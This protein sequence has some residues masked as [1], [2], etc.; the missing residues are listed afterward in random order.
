MVMYFIRELCRLNTIPNNLI[1]LNLRTDLSWVQRITGAYPDNTEIIVSQLAS[2]NTIRYDQNALI[3]Q[4]NMSDFFKPHFYPISFFYL[5]MLTRKDDF[6]L[7]LPNLSMKKIFIEYFNDI[8]HIDTSTRYTE[9]MERFIV[10]NP[11][12][13]ELFAGYWREYVSQLPEAIFAQVNEN[14]YRTTFYELCSRFLSKWFTFN[15]E[16][17]YPSGKSDLE[18]VGKFNEQFVGRRWVIEFK[19]FSNT[20]FSKLGGTPDEFTLRYED[21]E[22]ISGYAAG[23]IAEYPEVDISLHVIYCFGNQGFRVFD[24]APGSECRSTLPGDC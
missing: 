21:V 23:L 7:C 16:R 17:S 20:Q 2:E 9:F 12:I 1:D 10:S 18:F 19:Y 4:F 11:D 8:Y 6:Y 14:F 5:G 24:I 22:Q 3:S 13:G 15:I